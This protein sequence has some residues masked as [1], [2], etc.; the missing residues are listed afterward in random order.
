[1]EKR[2]ADPSTFDASLAD[3]ISAAASS[4]K[5]LYVLFTGAVVAETG[6]S[7]C[8]DCVNA[9]PIINKV[10]SSLES[11]C[12]LLECPVERSEYRSQEYLYRTL[13]SVQ[14]KCV[15]TLIKWS[16]SGGANALRLD[17]AQCQREELV[18]ELASS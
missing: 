15:P 17:D 2:H 14:L 10:L 1:M 7:W 6:R 8:P 12:I 18:E 16:S 11:G 9:D 5:P 4:R 13:P 3:A